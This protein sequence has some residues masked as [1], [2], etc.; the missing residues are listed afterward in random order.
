MLALEIANYIIFKHK[1]T[2][3][4]HSLGMEVMTYENLIGWHGTTKIRQKSISSEFFNFNSYIFGKEN[5]RQPNDL[6]NG[7][8]FYLPFFNDKG[9]IIAQQYVRKYKNKELIS[10]KTS[11]C[12]VKA[13]IKYLKE[14]S[15]DLNNEDNVAF[16][17]GISKLFEK[18]LL[19]EMKNIRDDGAKQRA[20]Q[21][22]DNKG[23]LIELVYQL[24]EKEHPEKKFDVVIKDT[25]TDIPHLKCDDKGNNGKE[26]AVRKLDLIEIIPKEE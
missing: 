25:Y 23:L 4:K 21:Q 10:N 26:I 24:Y 13:N 2:T 5:Q 3:Y 14:K 20:Q 8:Y 1:L 17:E 18:E 9:N 12:L 11:V 7:I 6:G 15:L 19:E 16:L 22:A